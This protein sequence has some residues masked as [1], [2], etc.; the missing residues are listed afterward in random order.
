MT[1]IKRSITVEIAAPIERVWEVLTDV[2]RWSE[3][4][5]T[6]TLVTRLDDRPLR[7]RCG[8][9]SSSPRFRRPN[10]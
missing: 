8:P 3:W 9:R 1:S 7:P 4:T 2:E 5:E 10:T 6:V